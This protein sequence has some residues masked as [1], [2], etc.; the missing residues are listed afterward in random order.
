M[1][2]IAVQDSACAVVGVRALLLVRESG[3]DAAY[4]DREG[5]EWDGVGC[6]LIFCRVQVLVLVIL[7]VVCP[8]VEEWWDRVCRR[9]GLLVLV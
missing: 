6:R 3:C 1:L 9:V 7:R 8:G 5:Q 2:C 4:M